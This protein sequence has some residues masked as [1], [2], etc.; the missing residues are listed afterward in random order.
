MNMHV[1]TY[2]IVSTDCIVFD[3]ALFI[4]LYSAIFAASMSINV[5]YSVF[6]GQIIFPQ[7]IQSYWPHSAARLPL[8]QPVLGMSDQAEDFQQQTPDLTPSTAVQN[9][10]SKNKRIVQIP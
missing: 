3:H 2:L 7:P 4:I 9:L 6:T 1:Y 8:Q 10:H 5:Q